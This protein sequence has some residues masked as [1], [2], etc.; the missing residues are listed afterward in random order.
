MAQI[1]NHKTRD[2]AIAMAHIEGLNQQLE[3][4][5]TDVRSGFENLNKNMGSFVPRAEL[6]LIRQRYDYMF[7]QMYNRQSKID[8]HTASMRKWMY[9][10]AGVLAG[11]I[12][13]NQLINL[14]VA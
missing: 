10:L 9:V 4:L 6:D 7:E 3:L 5:R 1:P 11:S 2:E 13:A 14:A 8:E 12:P